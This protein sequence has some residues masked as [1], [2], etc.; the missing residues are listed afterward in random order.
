MLKKLLTVALLLSAGAVATQAQRKVQP[1]GR[2]VVAVQNGSS[3]MLTWRRLAQ[4][5]EDCKYNIYVSKAKEGPFTLLN[6]SPLANTNYSTS[7]SKVPVGSYVAVSLIDGDEESNPSQPFLFRNQLQRNIFMEIHFDRSPLDKK[8]YTTK[9][10]WPCDLDGDGEYD[11]V[12]DRIPVD[13]SRN[14]YIEGYLADGTFLWNVDLGVNEKPCDGQNDNLCAYDID[15]DGKGELIVQTSDGTRLWDSQEGTWG[16]YLL[17]KDTPD[18]DGDGVT[19]YD[20]QGQRNPPRYMTVIDGMTGAEKAT[21]E[22][23]YDEAY[24]R[25]NKAALMGDEYNKHEGHVGIFYHDGVHPAIVGE[26][27][28]RSADGSTHYYRNVAFAYDG[29]EWKLLFSEK[30]GGSIFHQI[31]IADVDGDGCD[32]MLS[33]A[34]AMDQDGSTLYNSGI[35]HG[36]RHRISDI[37]PERPGLECF[38]IQQYAPD[39]LG[40]ILYD[41]AT[42]E[43]IKKWYLSAVGDV[44][45][46][47]CMDVDKNHLGWEMWSTMDGVYDAKGNKIEGLTNT[48]PTEGIWWDGNLDREILQTSDS[49]YNFYIQDYGGGRIVQ[50]AKDSGYQLKTSYGKRAKFWGDIIG[51]WREELVVIREV[52]GVCQGIVGLTTD[53]PTSVNNIYC[54]QQDP[55]YRGDCTTRGY[56]QSPNP[57]FYLGYDMPRPQLPPVMV[58]DESTDVFGISDGQATVTPRKG[59]KNIYVMPVKGQT[60]TINSLEG[61][62]TLWKSQQGTLALNGDCTTT[63]RT[64]ISEGTLLLNGSISG[65]VD[66]RARGT[67]A[68]NGS[69]GSILLEGA[70]NYEG[71]RIMPNG[72]ISVLGNLNLNRNTYIELDAERGDCVKVNGNLTVTQPVIFTINASDIKSGEYRL[73]EH[74][75]TFVGQLSRFSVRGLTGKACSIVDKDGA[76]CLVVKEQRDAA[77]G[78]VWTGM[79]SSSWDYKAEN[80]LLGGQSSTFVAGDGVVI[81]DDCTRTAIVVN[82]LM[83]VASVTFKNDEKSVTLSGEGGISGEGDVIVSGAGKVTFNTTKSNYTGKTIINSG[84][85]TVK[86]LAEAC[87]PSSIGAAPAAAD[88]FQIGKATLIISNANTSTDRGLTLN[89]TATIQVTSGTTSLKGLVKG[90]GVLRKTGAGQLNITRGGANTWRSTILQAGTLA[91]G[92][93]NTTFGIATSTIHVTGNATLNMFDSNS[94]SS[95]PIFQNTIDIDEGKMLTF[96]AGSRCAIKGALVGKGTFKVSFPYVRGDVYTNASKFEGV[97]EVAS[98]NCRFVQAMNLSKATLKL[99]EGAHAA[100]YKPGKGDEVS[101]THTIGTLTGTGTL[102][103]GTWQIARLAISYK[104]AGSAILCDAPTVNGTALLRNL[105]I[106]MSSAAGTDIPDGAEFAVIKGTGKRTVTGPVTVLPAQP[107]P[108]YEWDTSSLAS[109]GIITIKPVPDAVC[110]PEA[111]GNGTDMFTLSGTKAV[112][113]TE[114]IYITNKKK[115]ISR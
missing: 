24:N 37:D 64:V 3:V 55:H 10:V 5:P 90:S 71:G 87:T 85:V 7:I 103:T 61:E 115:I 39:M 26:W 51:D 70:L 35:A 99:D 107:K 30:P 1:L 46:G 97:Y 108:G 43:P 81:G 113:P 102:G 50:P 76:I 11:Y 36:D 40:Q 53:L 75:G 25:T 63:G 23:A 18:S 94:S 31:R 69:V 60:I 15:C 2:G 95:A 66:I 32:E 54:L 56:Y 101:Y 65:T 19:D 93:Y 77:N 67:L 114:G 74:T 44:G 73:I 105:V 86:E 80:F 33:G 22:F 111:V 20:T 91:M 6:P 4:E 16:E 49:H 83:P 48:Y 112:T 28:T 106:D 21:A 104:V 68:G 57:G 52:D 42:G 9:F 38:A 84:T 78:V 109:K 47:E 92:A 8:R 72:C 98:A 59:M 62:A 45:R 12:V 34:Y 27:H 88:Y 17:H 41:A 96:R 110:T 29:G 89:D 13:G 82:E 58:A 79:A 14:H 100:G